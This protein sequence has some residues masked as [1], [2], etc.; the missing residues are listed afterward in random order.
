MKIYIQDNNW[1][2]AIMVIAANEA[3]AR[4]LMEGCANYSKRKPVEEHE[5]KEGFIFYNVGDM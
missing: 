5:V 4:K 1:S 3:D 2:G